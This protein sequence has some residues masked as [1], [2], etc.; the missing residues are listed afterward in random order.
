MAEKKAEEKFKG[1]E[2]K[3]AVVFSKLDPHMARLLVQPIKGVKDVS[4]INLEPD[5][6]P[7]D[8]ESA[9]YDVEASILIRVEIKKKPKPKNK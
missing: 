3:G 5:I 9:T 6:F 7:K 8:F 2:F 1:H 4:V